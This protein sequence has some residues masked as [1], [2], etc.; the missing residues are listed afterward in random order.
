MPDDSATLHEP[1]VLQADDVADLVQPLPEVNAAAIDAAREQEAQA[2]A[3]TAPAPAAAPPLAASP[4]AAPS[5]ATPPRAQRTRVAVTD[6]KGRPFDPLLHECTDDGQPIMRSAPNDRWVRCRR[7]ALKEWRR[8][9]VVGEDPAPAAAQPQAPPPPVIDPGKQLMAAQTMAGI[10]IMAMRAALGDKIAETQAE[11]DELT[12]SWL[13]VCQHY[14]LGGSFHPVIGL[15]LVS[16]SLV[17]GALHHEDTRSRLQRAWD[18]AQLKALS[19]WQ[20][21][22]GG[23]NWTRPQPTQQRDQTQRPA[24]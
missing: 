10:Q 7:Q 21:L 19:V 20:V 18:W 14:G 24:A 16:G 17:V 11:R 8:K 5:P 13:A 22:R 2:Q 9:S 3:D 15:A 1:E 12:N 23:R 6:E 4:V